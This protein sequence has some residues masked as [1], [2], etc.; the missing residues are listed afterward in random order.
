MTTKPNRWVQVQITNYPAW[1]G[2]TRDDI[3]VLCADGSLRSWG[4][5]KSQPFHK[6]DGA[7]YETPTTARDSAIE[8][9]ARRQ[10][11]T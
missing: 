6:A 11:L 3:F 4:G 5:G 10:A 7:Q 8:R 9:G 1:K 2:I